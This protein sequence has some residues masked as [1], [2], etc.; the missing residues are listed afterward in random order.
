MLTQ[1]GR[2]H[3]D[4]D[5]LE[6]GNGFSAA[7]ERSHFA[8][9]AMMKSPLIIGTDI[10]LLS[11]DQLALLK[12][13]YLLG[14]NQDPVYGAPAAPFKWGTNPDWT[15]NM[16]FPAEYWA[17]EFS[18][19]TLIAMLNTFNSTVNKSANF[20]EIPGMEPEKEY[21]L[22]NIWTGVSLGRYKGSYTA[23][24]D[25]HDTAVVLAQLCDK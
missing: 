2:D 1:A 25:S 14:F 3:A 10:S 8:L 19:G 16:T 4:E 6:V 7:E 20:G 21:E 11:T 23:S 9:W 5:M 17:G 22:T 13:P 24:V 12:N 15:W 18:N